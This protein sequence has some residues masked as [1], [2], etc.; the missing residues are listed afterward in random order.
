MFMEWESVLISQPELD[1][2]KDFIFSSIFKVK[3]SEN[4]GPES[5]K[6]PEWVG[7]VCATTLF[8]LYI[9]MDIVVTSRVW[10][11][12]FPSV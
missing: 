12:I 8:S 9:F 11:D 3:P 10:D 7:T 6:L 1:V 4:K 2:E 5:T